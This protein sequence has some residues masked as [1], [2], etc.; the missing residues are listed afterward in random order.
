MK[1]I[2]FENRGERK[3]QATNDISRIQGRA[4]GFLLKRGASAK[5]FIQRPFFPQFPLFS[6]KIIWPY[7]RHRA[8]FPWKIK[9]CEL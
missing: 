7:P 1:T 3:F 5:V 8:H 2:L 4:G 6:L 9:D